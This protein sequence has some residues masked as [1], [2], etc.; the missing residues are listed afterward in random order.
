MQI[1]AKELGEEEEEEWVKRGG[2]VP[3]SDRAVHKTQKTFLFFLFFS[4]FISGF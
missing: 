4:R 1:P 3:C 2:V